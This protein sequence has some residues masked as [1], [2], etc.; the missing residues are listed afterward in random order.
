MPIAELTDAHV[1]AFKCD[2]NKRLVELRDAMLPGLE[3]RVTAGGV[4]SWRLHYTRRSDGKRRAVPLGR[5][6]SL[7]LKDARRKSET[8]SVGDRRR[9][10][11]GRSSCE[12]A[13]SQRGSEVR[14]ACR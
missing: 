13:G 1:K 12:A 14:G 2:A 9:N 7:S 11:V 6:P 8:A 5:Y 3:L 10:E 4:K